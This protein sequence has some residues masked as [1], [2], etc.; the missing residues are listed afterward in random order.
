M[1]QNLYSFTE[2]LTQLIAKL[3]YYIL[4]GHPGWRGGLVVGRR[5]CD[6]VV[7]GSRPGPNAAA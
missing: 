3:N 1:V 5:T 2:C 6:L 7:R 4:I